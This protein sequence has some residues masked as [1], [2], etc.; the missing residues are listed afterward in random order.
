MNEDVLQAFFIALNLLVFMLESTYTMHVQGRLFTLVVSSFPT[1]LLMTSPLLHTL[2]E[3][4]LH[5]C[6]LCT[7]GSHAVYYEYQNREAA[8]S[9]YILHRGEG[10][11]WEQGYILLSQ[12]L[13]HPP[14][15]LLNA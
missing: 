10:R 4:N 12:L 7:I 9:I 6:L 8:Q 5:C 3:N 15:P 14:A 1:L 11:A 13:M 2:V